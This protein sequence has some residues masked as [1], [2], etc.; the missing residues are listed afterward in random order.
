MLK[1]R[2]KVEVLW[3]I[4]SDILYSM[5]ATDNDDTLC[6]PKNILKETVP[7]ICIPGLTTL[8]TT[9]TCFS[10]F[11]WVFSIRPMGQTISLA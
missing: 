4:I 1:S 9:L 8:S 5:V 7:K 6:I 3:D 10:L 11:I 2:Y